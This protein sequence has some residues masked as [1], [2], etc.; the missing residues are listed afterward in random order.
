MMS[1]L[2][3]HWH[4]MTSRRRHTSEKTTTA[5]YGHTVATPREYDYAMFMENAQLGERRDLGKCF[6]AVWRLIIV[7]FHW[8]VALLSVHYVIVLF[9]AFLFPLRS[10]TFSNDTLVNPLN[11]ILARPAARRRSMGTKMLLESC[12]QAWKL[13]FLV[14]TLA[15]HV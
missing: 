4:R 3:G 7:R 9:S 2:W 12:S 15:L 14:Y 8:I 11:H 13:S 10:T 6:S 5:I 1:W